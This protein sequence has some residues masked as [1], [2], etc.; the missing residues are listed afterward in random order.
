MLNALSEIINSESI[1]TAF[2]FTLLITA[3]TL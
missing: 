3:Y 1:Y 2:A